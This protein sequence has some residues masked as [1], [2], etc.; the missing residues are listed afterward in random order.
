MS[1]GE[2]GTYNLH[3]LLLLA[4]FV[5]HAYSVTP[6]I[7]P[8]LILL[9]VGSSAPEGTQVNYLNTWLKSIKIHCIFAVATNDE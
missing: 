1:S 8:L 6:V 5:S 2:L 7:Y 9:Y 3:L 4:S